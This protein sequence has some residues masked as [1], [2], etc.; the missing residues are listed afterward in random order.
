MVFLPE[1]K[2]RKHL[3]NQHFLSIMPHSD[4]GIEYCSREYQKLMN[5]LGVKI[6]MSKKA[7]PWENGYQE[8]FF[9]NFKTD[10]GLEFDRF[11]SLGEFVEAIC[12]QLYYYN[13]ERIQLALKM[14]PLKFKQ[15]YYQ[16]HQLN[17]CTFGY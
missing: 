16:N 7:S 12:Q 1:R 9:D 6:S 14:S 15:R 17:T 10:L 3:K 4:Q 2:E 13:H 5:F 11:N 8:S